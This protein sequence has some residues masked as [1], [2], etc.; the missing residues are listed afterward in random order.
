MLG[1]YPRAGGRTET[2]IHTHTH[3]APAPAAHLSCSP[4]TSTEAR[5]FPVTL[6]TTQLRKKRMREATKF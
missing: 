6:L 5:T 4:N 1:S 2:H 3:P